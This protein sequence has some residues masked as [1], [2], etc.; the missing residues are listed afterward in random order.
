MLAAKLVKGVDMPDVVDPRESGASGV[1][2]RARL[3]LIGV[4]SGM[5]EVEKPSLSNRK[6]TL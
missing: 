2:S 5:L 3:F 1:Q 6:C 4:L